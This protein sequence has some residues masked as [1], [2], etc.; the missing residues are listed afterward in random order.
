MVVFHRVKLPEGILQYELQDP[1][2]TVPYKAIFGWDI[3]I[4][5]PLYDLYGKYLQLRFLK[6]PSIL[7]EHPSTRGVCHHSAGH[8]LPARFKRRLRRGG[9][10]GV[11]SIGARRSRG[12]LV[13]DG[14]GS[15][16]ELQGAAGSCRASSSWS[17]VNDG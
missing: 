10:G 2:G 6:F 13:V 15:C 16:R 3:P 17:M 9:P 8:R 14:A 4:Y 12:Q 11:P 7:L 5:R 1:R